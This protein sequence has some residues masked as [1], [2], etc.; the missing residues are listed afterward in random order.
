V[1]TIQ[2]VEVK[3]KEIVRT[4]KKRRLGVREMEKKGTGKKKINP[5]EEKGKE[6]I[7]SGV[8]NAFHEGPDGLYFQ[9]EESKE[10]TMRP[11]KN[12]GSGIFIPEGKRPCSVSPGK[13]LG[14]TGKKGGDL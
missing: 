8:W 11:K 2:E 9:K 6:N 3:S 5:N 14:E 10:R 7:I 4:F 1:G 12:P 13:N